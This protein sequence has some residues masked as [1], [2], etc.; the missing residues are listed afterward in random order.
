MEE[1]LNTPDMDTVLQG[2]KP[3]RREP[4]S[5]SGV[6]ES[7][8]D[9]C[10]PHFSPFSFLMAKKNSM[11]KKVPRH[12][13]KKTANLAWRGMLSMKVLLYPHL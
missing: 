3:I 11:T 4:H 8:A 13:T 6:V 1:K 2:L 9:F 10:S 5:Q 12:L 7:N